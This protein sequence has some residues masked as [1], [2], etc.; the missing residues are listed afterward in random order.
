MFGSILTEKQNLPPFLKILM[1]T[2]VHYFSTVE[3]GSV[4]LLCSKLSEGKL[5]T[6]TPT[7][8]NTRSLGPT[9]M[10]SSFKGQSHCGTPG[11]SDPSLCGTGPCLI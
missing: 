6:T 4:A 2:R 1:N 5:H 11:F 9:E 7:L 8:G 10:L 3:E